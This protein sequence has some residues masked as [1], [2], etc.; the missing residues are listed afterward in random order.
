MKCI[1]HCVLISLLFG[2]RVWAQVGLSSPPTA[3]SVFQGTPNGAPSGIPIKVVS[4]IGEL[5]LSVLGSGLQP[6]PCRTPC[7]AR[8]P[9]GKA[10]LVLA[11]TGAPSTVD[12]EKPSIVTFESRSNGKLVGGIVVV[13]LSV[14]MLAVAFSGQ[15]GLLDAVVLGAAGGGCFSIGGELISKSSG[16]V[17]VAAWQ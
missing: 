9:R 5:Q 1:I 17:V 13:T 16:G 7:E 8:V 11:A 14:A 2:T 10:N 12:I 15:V 4:E 6:Q 3:P